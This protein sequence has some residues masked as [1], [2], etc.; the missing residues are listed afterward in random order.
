MKF[1][2]NNRRERI[3]KY[4]SLGDLYVLS[5]P[6]LTFVTTVFRTFGNTPQQVVWTDK[7]V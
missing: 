3:Y 5:L 7:M 6:T 2:S 4:T 1:N